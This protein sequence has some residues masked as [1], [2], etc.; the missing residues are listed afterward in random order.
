MCD[1][2]ACSATR[3]CNMALKTIRNFDVTKCNA[4]C[5]DSDM[6]NAIPVSS[7][8]TEGMQTIPIPR[9]ARSTKRVYRTI[10]VPMTTE[11]EVEEYDFTPAM[12]INCFSCQEGSELDVCHLLPS[13]SRCGLEYDSC[14]SITG[15]LADSE[16]IQV[17]YRGCGLAETNCNITQLCIDVRNKLFVNEGKELA[18]CNG[19]CCRNNFCNNFNPTRPVQVSGR[20]KTTKAR[21]TAP[22]KKT[23]SKSPPIKCYE[24]KPE[25][26]GTMCNKNT[27]SRMCETGYH[28]YDS[29]MT[30]TAVIVNSTTNEVFQNIIL[31]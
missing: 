24:C 16:N 12:G 25:A 13:V 30:M 18:T 8:P 20:L 11:D 6:C 29:C 15:T 26:F 1:N 23:P 22:A 10:G 17:A 2:G 21:R 19:Y 9:A 31:F 27:T 5:C 7:T 14:V 3:L 28:G 4:K